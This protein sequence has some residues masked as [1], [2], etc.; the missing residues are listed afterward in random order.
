MTW[1]YV[2][3]AASAMITAFF[4][5]A[6]VLGA[7]VCLRVYSLWGAFMW[8]VVYGMGTIAAAF[9]TSLIHAYVMGSL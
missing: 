3:L 6:T 2:A 5:V 9:A 4:V 7:L 1:T 8:F